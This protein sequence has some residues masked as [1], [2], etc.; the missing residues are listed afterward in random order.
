MLEQEGP[1]K[2]GEPVTLTLELKAEGALGNQLPSLARH[3]E[4][5]NY[6]IY[7]DAT[8]IKNGI[9]ANGEYLTGS[10]R[11]TFTIIPLEDGWIRL[12]R[13]ALAWWDVDS[14]SAKVAEL[15]FGFVDK[16]ASSSQATATGAGGHWIN[17]FYFWAPLVITLSVIVGI[18]LGAWRRTRPLFKA[19]AA[20]LLSLGHHARQTIYRAGIRLSPANHL[21]RLRIGL[22]VLMPRSVKLWMCTRCLQTEENPEAWCTQFKSRVCQHLDLPMHAPL[23][24][25]AE[26]IITTSPQTEPARLRTLVHS[27]DAAIYGGSSLDFPAWKGELTGLLRPR[28]L[29]RRWRTR[30]TSTTLP[31]LNPHSMRFT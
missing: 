5:S 31:A 11:E 27:L 19:A 21:R 17:P 9:S 16:A 24:Q 18:W 13:V 1:A 22:A 7:R 2:A 29:R 30:K 25:I 3:L 12:P 20:W 8:A 4:S 14:H 26:K 6:R 28:L 23:T 10:R 15:P